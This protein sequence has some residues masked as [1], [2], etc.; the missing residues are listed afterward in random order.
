MSNVKVNGNTYN[1]VTSVKLPLADGSG[2]AV[3]KEGQGQ[4]E[5]SLLDLLMTGENLGDYTN[6]EI[7]V[8]NP[9]IISYL[10]F[11]TWNFPNAAKVKGGNIYNAIGTNLLMP[12]AVSTYIAT[13]NFRNCKISGILDMRNFTADNKASDA[14]FLVYGSTIGTLRLDSLGVVGGSMI[15]T[16]TITNLVW[17][18]AGLTADGIKAAL[19]AA[20]AITNL[21]ITDAIYDDVQALI[22]AGTITKVT[23]L[24]KYSEW[25]D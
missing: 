18:G 11:G 22:T 8:F 21:Y 25:S 13:P 7:T 20:T 17:G 10:T 15:A 1:D 16:A 4:E 9:A 6:E 5:N 24:H 3:Y 2:Y 23:N 12:N 14:A 19:N